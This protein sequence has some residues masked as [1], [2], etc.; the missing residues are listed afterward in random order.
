MIRRATSRSAVDAEERR[1]GVEEED[2]GVSGGERRGVERDGKG[3]GQEGR[4]RGGV[5]PGTRLVPAFHSHWPCRSLY[6][7]SSSSF[8]ISFSSTSALYPC[9]FLPCRERERKKALLD[10]LPPRFLPLFPSFSSSF[11]FGRLLNVNR[12][13]ILGGPSAM[14]TSSALTSQKSRNSQRVR[15]CDCK[16]VHSSPSDFHFIVEFVF[17]QMECPFLSFLPF[18]L[19]LSLFRDY[20]LELERGVL[21]FTLRRAM[22]YG[23]LWLFLPS[24]PRLHACFISRSSAVDTPRSF[25]LRPRFR[26]FFSPNSRW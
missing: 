16:C 17:V 24:L 12:I 20:L 26:L 22:V 13:G 14:K 3:A 25:A 4:K 19:S 5:R 21:H 6:R 11:Y 10:Q 1:R 18:F 7:W 8:S 9:S 15:P 23:L 2:E